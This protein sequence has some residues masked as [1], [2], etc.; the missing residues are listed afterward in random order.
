[1]TI[2]LYSRAHRWAKE[3][4][5]RRWNQAWL[6]SKLRSRRE[7]LQFADAIGRK[8]DTV[9]NLIDAYNFFTTLL[10]AAWGTH[11]WWTL[12]KLA[13][14]A[15][16]GHVLTGLIGTFLPPL[17]IIHGVMIWFGRGLG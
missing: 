16:S 11:I 13:T 5:G 14:S 17:G 10:L 3:A 1:M 7:I 12:A 4:D 2:D 6:A 8:E 9:R 15:A